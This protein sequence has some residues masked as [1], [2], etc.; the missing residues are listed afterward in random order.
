[1]NESSE[2]YWF[3][4][5]MM[6]FNALAA[7]LGMQIIKAENAVFK[8]SVLLLSVP[9]LWLWHVFYGDE[10]DVFNFAKLFAQ[11]LLIVATMFY[12]MFDR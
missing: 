11:L 9:T 2:L 10:K 1:M 5:G 12:L 6:F 7:N 4:F 8:Q 3:M